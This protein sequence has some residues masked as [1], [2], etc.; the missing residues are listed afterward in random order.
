MAEY[1]LSDSIDKDRIFIV[2][3]SELD[4]RLEPKFYTQKYIDNENRLK[5]S[6]Y[7]VCHLLE[8]TDKI[9]DGTHFTPNYKEEG[10]KFISVKDVRK[11]SINLNDTKFI[12]EEEADKLDKRCK[13]Q[14][15]DV[16]LTKIGATFGFAATVETTERF[17]IFVSLALLRPNSKIIPQF[18]EIF[19]NTDLAYIQYDRVIKGAGVPDLHLE[20]IRKV[21]ISLPPK[22]IQQEIVNRYHEALNNK[23]Q[24]EKEAQDLLNGIDD[25]LLKEL[26]IT[27]PQRQNDLQSRI[28]TISFSEVTGSRFDPL[29]FSKSIL[30]LFESEFEYVPLMKCA[31]GFVSGFGAGRSEQIGEDN[32]VVQIRPTNINSQGNLK[33]DKNVYVPKNIIRS[34]YFLKHKDILFN[35]TNSQDLVG[36]TS[37]YENQL[38]EA[39][40]SNHITKFSVNEDAVNPYYLK[41]ILNL[42]QRHRYFYSICTNW[43]NQSGVGIELLKQVRVPLPDL[44]VQNQIASYVLDLRNAARTIEQKAAS[45]FEFTKAEI[46]KLILG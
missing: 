12:S 44:T 40:F 20:D 39:T 14:L 29:I 46:E 41:E 4:F 43:N 3:R 19:L 8:V 18:L 11:S 6:K 17:Q 31:Y 22:K 16:L 30:F 13:P 10:I 25:Y 9:S 45:S 15:N 5:S 2:K 7:T 21:K 42:Y 32:G 26:G 37:I 23:Q 36:K 1:S 28:F 38:P 35:N 33:F 27:L 34:N 24:K